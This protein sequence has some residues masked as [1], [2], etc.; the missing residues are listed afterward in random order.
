VADKA[1]AMTDGDSMLSR[2]N[3]LE[4]AQLKEYRDHVRDNVIK[5]LDNIEAVQKQ[6]VSDLANLRLSFE[7]QRTKQSVLEKTAPAL[8]GFGGS[9]I[10]ALILY[11]LHLI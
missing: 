10:V 7:K 9:G 1:C 2:V 8:T 3:A 11:F 6:T 4:I 5:R